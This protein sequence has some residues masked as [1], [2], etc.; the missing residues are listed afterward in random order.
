MLR[1]EERDACLYRPVRMGS[2]L[3]VP[4]MMLQVE[5]RARGLCWISA[6]PPANSSTTQTHKNH[7]P[8]HHAMV[9]YTTANTSF[10]LSPPLLDALYCLQRVLLYSLVPSPCIG[11]ALQGLLYLGLTV[12]YLHLS[13]SSL[14]KDISR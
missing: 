10:I 8:A 7:R 14:I 6:L 1:G 11:A 3:P 12:S 5:R 2:V 9:I 13:T 4:G